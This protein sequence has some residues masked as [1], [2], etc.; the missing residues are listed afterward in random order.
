MTLPSP[1]R[2]NCL[3]WALCIKLLYGGQVR[4]R[5]S[6]NWPGP[7]WYVVLVNG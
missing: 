3:V 2:S 6:L 5:M 1:A 7:H 4:W